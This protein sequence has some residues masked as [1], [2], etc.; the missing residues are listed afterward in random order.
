V[1]WGFSIKEIGSKTSRLAARID[2]INGLFFILAQQYLIGEHFL[3]RN[4][5]DLPT[6]TTMTTSIF[7]RRR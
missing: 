3:H 5:I 6:T 2:N 7:P 1:H 4:D